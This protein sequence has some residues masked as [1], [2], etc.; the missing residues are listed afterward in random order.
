MPLNREQPLPSYAFPFSPAEIERG[1]VHEF[2]LNHVVQVNDPLELVRT[3][4][5]D[6][7]EL[8]HA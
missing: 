2:L 5:V 7:G 1:A 6:A 4:F 3:E 8:Q